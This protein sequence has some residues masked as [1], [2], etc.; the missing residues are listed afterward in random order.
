MTDK[1][2]I[3]KEIAAKHGIAV[4]R[5]NPIADPANH[6]RTTHADSTAAQQVAGQLQGRVGGGGCRWERTPG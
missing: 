2:E 6:Q 1:I 4:G 5:D 3:I